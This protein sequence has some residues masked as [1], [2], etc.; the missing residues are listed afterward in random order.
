MTEKPEI[1]ASLFCQVCGKIIPEDKA[2]RRSNTCGEKDC[3]NAL[4]RFRA[5]IL[6][7]GK[8]PHCY[9]PSTPEEWAQYRQWRQWVANQNDTTLQAFMKASSGMT[10][11][12][13]TRK[14]A[15]GLQEAQKAMEARRRQ[16]LE[17]STLKSAGVPDLSTLPAEAAEEIADLEELIG[18]WSPLLEAAK[19]ALPERTP[20]E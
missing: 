8:C 1:P 15:L 4:R 11:R 9:H 10:L 18:T 16:V 13:L 7:T 17:Q 3:V 20:A 6:N 2:K 19:E 14:L 5:A 12:A